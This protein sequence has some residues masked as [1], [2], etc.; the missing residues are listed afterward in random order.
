MEFN[1]TTPVYIIALSIPF[2]CPFQNNS[3][4]LKGYKETLACCQSR[5]TLQKILSEHNY[6][7]K[8]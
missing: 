7:N 3:W 6:Q 5:L 2:H 4:P 8:L 1:I